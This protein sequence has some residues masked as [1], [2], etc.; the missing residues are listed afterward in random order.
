M[1]KFDAFR[2]VQRTIGRSAVP[3][4]RKF[5][6]RAL[7]WAMLLW[8]AINQFCLWLDRWLFPGFLSVEVRKPIF[9]IAHPRSGTT[10][11]HRLM[12]ADPGRYS[13][14][15]AYELLL[16][17]ITQKKLVRALGWLDRKFLRETLHQ[18]VR[19]KESSALGDLQDIH[20]F[21]LLEAEE[22]EWFYFMTFASGVSL[23]LFPYVEEFRE[24]M[25]F[26][27]MPQDLQREHMDYYHG[28]LQ[29]QLYLDGPEKVFCSKNTTTF[30]PKIE[31][32]AQRYPD[33]RFV[34]IV[35]NPLEVAP[36]LLSL[37]GSTWRQMGFPE[38][39][40]RQG[41]AVIH[42]TNM[43]A[44]ERAFEAL[45]ALDPSRY[46][47]LDYRDIAAAPKTTMTAVY[48]ALGIEMTPAYES[49]LDEL[50]ERA[51]KHVS[52][53]SYGLEEFGL[54][55]SSIRSDTPTVFQR[56]RFD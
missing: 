33:S 20:H 31:T 5:F 34:H 12:L 28:C 49:V 29:R 37:L 4:G 40:I 48:R 47:I 3:T 46:H 21:S 54:D 56:Y 42:A 24:V 45:D 26:D 32:L 2:K 14:A 39:D 7:F 52:G 9:I 51:R 10:L 35:R 36:S 27:Q 18:W 1:L 44:Y 19:S 15:R 55:E 30:I 43:A 6:L 11:T 53:H 23:S 13:F 50:Q 38:E 41:L 8:G 17:S 16:P 22:D 25:T